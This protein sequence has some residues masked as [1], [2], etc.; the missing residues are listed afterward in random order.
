MKKSPKTKLEYIVAVKVPRRKIDA[1]P[2]NTRKLADE[3][4]DTIR[5]T[6][7]PGATLSR[8]FRVKFVRKRVRSHA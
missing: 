1:R 5:G 4:E 3:Y 6:L 7:P 2:F 8:T